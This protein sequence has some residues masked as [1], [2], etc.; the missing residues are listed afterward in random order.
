MAITKQKVKEGKELTLTESNE[1]RERNPGL[2]FVANHKGKN[3]FLTVW[4]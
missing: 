1:I 2:K 4:R 3:I